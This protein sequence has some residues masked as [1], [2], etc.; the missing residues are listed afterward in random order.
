MEYAKVCMGMR[1][2]NARYSACEGG[3]EPRHQRLAVA[4][5]IGRRQS[6]GSWLFSPRADSKR[7]TCLRLAQ[8]EG[9]PVAAALGW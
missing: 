2:G 1:L 4:V 3:R 5:M 9:A 6:A 7:L 8:Q